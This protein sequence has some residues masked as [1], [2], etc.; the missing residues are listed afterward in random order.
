M[1]LDPG[2]SRGTIKKRYKELS[3]QWHPDKNPGCEDCRE[4]YE[5]L[6]K[7]YDI[8]IDDIER[9]NYD[10]SIGLSKDLRSKTEMVTTENFE[11]YFGA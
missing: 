8:L 5:T 9:S 3:L 7:A 2:A 1:G 10:E 6:V 4:K 11:E